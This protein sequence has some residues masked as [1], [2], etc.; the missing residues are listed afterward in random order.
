MRARLL[1]IVLGVLAAAGAAETGVR[2]GVQ[3][4]GKLYRSAFASGPGVLSRADLARVAE[5][6][7]SR[8]QRHLERRDAFKSTFRSR[9]ESMQD[10]R[11]DAKR[12][13]LERSI[14]SLVETPD[15]AAT[16]AGFVAAAPVSAEWDGRPEGPLAEA[17][18]A[19]NVLKKDPASP[20]APWL[21]AYIAVRQRIAFEASGREQDVEGMRTAAK[22]YRAFVER[23][24]AVEDPVYPALVEDME[25]LPFLYIKGSA[26][27]RDYDPDT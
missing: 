8:L 4:E 26:H 25:R 11:S 10:V 6:L 15:V 16:A 18:F 17:T 19:E 3:L 27:P 24:R 23:A 20:L 12:R 1:A 14:V 2:Q 5:P 13:L 21:Y 7:R 22:K 9:P